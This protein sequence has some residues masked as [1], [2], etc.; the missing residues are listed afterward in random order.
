[1]ALSRGVDPSADFGNGYTPLMFAAQRGQLEAM[2]ILLDAGADPNALSPTGQCAL[3]VAVFWG[4]ESAVRFLL[5]HQARPSGHTGS[6]SAD[7]PLVCAA[8]SG[9]VSNETLELLIRAGADVNE[10]DD[11]GTTPLIAARDAGLDEHVDVLI[12]AGARFGDQYAD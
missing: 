5:D 6:K 1:M 10:T 12:R 8:R 2:Q 11:Q 9:M 4:Q 7:P 3:G